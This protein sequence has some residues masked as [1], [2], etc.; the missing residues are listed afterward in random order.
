MRSFAFRGHVIFF[1]Y[2]GDTIEIV[3]VL[4][5]HRDSAAQFDKDKG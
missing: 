5:R 3:H 2:L 4:E 1:R